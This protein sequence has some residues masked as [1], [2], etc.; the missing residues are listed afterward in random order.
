MMPKTRIGK[1]AIVLLAVLVGV[2]VLAAIVLLARG[3]GNAPIEI[4]LPATGESTG[5]AGPSGANPAGVISAEP[6]LKVYI[7]GAVRYPGVYR[8]QLGD[9]FEDALAAAG[10]ATSEADLEAV[11]LARRVK[12]EAYYHVPRTGE[13]PRSP[14]ETA[15]DATIVQDSRNAG[16][17]PDSGLV[18]LNT[19]SVDLLET[20]PGIGEVR[21]Q[22]IV[23]DRELNGPFRSVEEVIRVQGIGDATYNNIR[24]LVRVGP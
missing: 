1:S 22:A 19:A 20:L 4:V 12:D 21:A 6:E 8:L 14:V 16:S 2:L 9:R 10:G 11:N 18:D 13:S 24:A 5:G 7:A 17:S 15:S 3:D 23:D